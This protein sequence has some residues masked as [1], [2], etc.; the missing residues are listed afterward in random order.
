MAWRAQF[1]YG[2]Q[3]NLHELFAF[4]TCQ[5]LLGTIIHMNLCGVNNDHHQ[6]YA[7]WWCIPI[8]HPCIPARLLCFSGFCICGIPKAHWSSC[9]GGCSAT[10]HH[11]S[12]TKPND[13]QF[14]TM[15]SWS[16]GT[17][18]EL[19][20]SCCHDGMKDQC[21]FRSISP[22]LFLYC[23]LS[24]NMTVNA[25]LLI[26]TKLSNALWLDTSTLANQETGLWIFHSLHLDCINVFAQLK[27]NWCR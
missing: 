15:A 7:P 19:C 8:S 27:K 14:H 4:H 11:S 26:P 17:A 22:N 24:I 12:P 9:I 25:C 5:N 2:S 10:E 6:E 21:I 23:L 13:G 3:Y 16:E 18:S 20:K 1:N